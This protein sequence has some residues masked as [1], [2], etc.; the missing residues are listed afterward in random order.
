MYY[1]RYLYMAMFIHQER[2]GKVFKRLNI[3]G[4]CRSPQGTILHPDLG[5]RHRPRWAFGCALAALF[6]TMDII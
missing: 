5:R 6:W 1:H 4:R 3:T 2:N